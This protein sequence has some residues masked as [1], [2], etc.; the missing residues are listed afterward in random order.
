M[1]MKNIKGNTQITVAGINKYIYSDF[2]FFL[3]QKRFFT[4]LYQTF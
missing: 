3:E 4:V 2:N 1:Q